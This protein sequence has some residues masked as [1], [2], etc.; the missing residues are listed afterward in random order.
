MPHVTIREEDQ[1]SAVELGGRIRGLLR[2]VLDA[3]PAQP[4][5]GHAL[6]ESLGIEGTTARRIIRATRDSID[7]LEVL[8]RSPAPDAL[9]KLA[10]SAATRVDQFVILEL[11]KAADRLDSLSRRYNGRTAFV[12]ALRDR[13]FEQSS[14]VSA[15]RIDPLLPIGERRILIIPGDTRTGR[16]VVDAATGEQWGIWHD[17]SFMTNTGLEAG[18]SG[19]HVMWSGGLDRDEPFA[20]DPR[21]W[22]PAILDDLRSRLRECLDRS[23]GIR[24]LLRPHA[25]HVLADLNRCVSFAR[26][27][28]TDPAM[29]SRI[30]FALDPAALFEPSMLPTQSDYL[31]RILSSLGAR[32]E[33]LI[34]SGLTQHPEAIDEEEPSPMQACPVHHGVLD[35]GILGR[36]V[37]EYCPVELPILFPFPDTGAQLASLDADS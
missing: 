28:C 5:T 15:S 6:T 24:L 23:P 9:R 35:V 31:E 14:P 32:C 16:T 27:L 7:E 20:R 12:R 37:R 29:H 26:D 3:L 34:L 2:A 1:A 33:L 18:A 8:S 13:A 30:G 25:R 19:N 11:H 22:S 17:H 36:L 4:R 21:L 10:E